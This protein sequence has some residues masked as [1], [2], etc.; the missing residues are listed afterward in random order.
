M[1]CNEKPTSKPGLSMQPVASEAAVVKIILISKQ[2][3]VQHSVWIC[4]S[5]LPYCV[6]FT[7]IVSSWE[8]ANIRVC[9]R[10]A[11]WSLQLRRFID[12]HKQRFTFSWKSA[13]ISLTGSVWNI[14][15]ARKQLTFFRVNPISQSSFLLSVK[16]TYWSYL[17]RAQNVPLF[18]IIYQN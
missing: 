3:R 1:P 11:V 9:C 5:R 17:R 14:F 7:D 2:T 12:D 18:V 16:V 13:Y 10:L 6:C 8:G 15:A 4:L